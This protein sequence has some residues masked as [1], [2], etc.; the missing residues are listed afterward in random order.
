MIAVVFV[1]YL[2]VPEQR[3]QDHFAWNDSAYRSFGDRLR[4]YVVSDVPHDLPPYAKCLVFP[5]DRLPLID[6]QRRFSLTMTKNF[7]IAKAAR[8]GADAIV[9]TDVDIAFDRPTLQA[10]FAVDDS[11]A[12]IPL[13][14]MV[15]SAQ[16][17]GQGHYDKGCT[18]T[19][20]MTASNW[21]RVSYD[22]RC[23]GY[24][25]DDGILLRDIERAGI[26]ILRNQVVYHVAHVAGDGQR[27][28]GSGSETCWGRDDGFN[29]DNFEHNRRLHLSRPLV[30]HYRP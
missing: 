30:R 2:K 3:L 11:T 29:F 22:E 4:V 25:A 17:K 7:G 13:Y 15:P 23:V 10:L 1:S 19:V 5:I 14:R 26:K 24:G 21:Q 9:C 6:G 18:G 27:N 28:P 20:S 8:N 16:E 12:A